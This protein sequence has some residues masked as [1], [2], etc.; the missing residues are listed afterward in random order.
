MNEWHE[1]FTHQLNQQ[2]T[3]LQ[4]AGETLN[5]FEDLAKVWPE[6]RALLTER[7]LPMLNAWIAKLGQAA[8][9]LSDTNG[10]LNVLYTKIEEV[11]RFP[12]QTGLYTRVRALKLA[13][14]LLSALLR[15][16]FMLPKVLR[17]TPLVLSIVLLFEY[18]REIIV[19]L[20]HYLDQFLGQIGSG[21]FP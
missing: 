15:F 9:V 8:T 4:K 7:L 21:N 10:P 14:L 18:R 12:A 20:E 13:N 5:N 2:G 3:T 11:K 16:K 6:R 19:I 17:L 1:P